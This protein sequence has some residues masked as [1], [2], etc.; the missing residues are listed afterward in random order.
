[1]ICSQAYKERIA[2]SFF[3][4]IQE[5]FRYEDNVSLLDSEY[6]KDKYMSS[7]RGLI[8]KYDNMAEVDKLIAATDK[9]EVIIDN[10]KRT[11]VNLLD[12][13][14]EIDVR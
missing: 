7:I 5:L 3:N 13:G 9:T 2:Y 1:M 6:L 12:K 8:A 14:N 11:I 4:Q 10:C